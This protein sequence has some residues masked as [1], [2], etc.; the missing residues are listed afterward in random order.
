MTEFWVSQA[1]YWCKICKC[2]IKDNKSSR[3]I[4][5]G[6]ARHAEN[7]REHLKE[8]WSKGRKIR[9]EQRELQDEL[10]AIEDAALKDFEIDLKRKGVAN[11]RENARTALSRNAMVDRGHGVRCGTADSTEDGAAAEIPQWKRAAD[12][13]A[14]AMRVHFYYVDAQGQQQGP[15]PLAHMQTWYIQG[16]LPTGTMVAVAGGTR[17]MEVSRCAAICAPHSEAGAL[18]LSEAGQMLSQQEEKER[19]AEFLERRKLELTADTAADRTTDCSAK[20]ASSV[21]TNSNLT[22]LGGSNAKVV[23]TGSIKH[24]V[25]C[26]CPECMAAKNGGEVNCARDILSS[27][28]SKEDG[29]VGMAPFKKVKI[30]AG[31]VGDR[32]DKGYG[33]W[34]AVASETSYTVGAANAR[35]D[36]H[37]YKI[38]ENPDDSSGDDDDDPRLEYRNP[39]TAMVGDDCAS[40]KATIAFQK[41]T[42]KSKNKRNIRKKT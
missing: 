23:T 24:S 9:D 39:I 31:K 41:R 35:L 1:N 12:A 22:P 19:Q 37:N 4:H 34:E 11:Y 6:G 32:D 28:D 15:H 33:K 2:W 16:Q 17:W 10:R 25:N 8:V 3:A 42:L 21:S 5:E 7:L 18:E 40:S 14:A 29:D 30:D 13:A 26:G 27:S 20:A 38:R 36:G